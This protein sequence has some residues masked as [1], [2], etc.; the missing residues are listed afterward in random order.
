MF[1]TVTATD[2]DL[3]VLRKLYQGKA[4]VLLRKPFDGEQSFQNCRLFGHVQHILS[5]GIVLDDVD[6]NRD[7]FYPWSSIF[8]LYAE[9][10]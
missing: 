1:S 8:R 4:V 5:V 7:A 9:H 6:T 2:S 3:E 10:V